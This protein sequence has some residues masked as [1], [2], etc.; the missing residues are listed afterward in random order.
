MALQNI[1]TAVLL[2]F[3]AGTVAASKR[4]PFAFYRFKKCLDNKVPLHVP[5][6]STY[7]TL[8][9]HNYRNGHVSPTAILL[10]RDE[11]EVQLGVRCAHRTGHKLCV[12]SGGH[13]FVGNSLCAGILLDVG[14]FRS[15]RFVN[16][17]HHLDI[18][19]G[20]TL[21]EVVWKSWN[22]RR[23]W[24]AAGV[25]PGVGISGYMLG[26][27]HGPYEGRLG[28]ACDALVSL[29]VV[30]RF[31]VLRVASRWRYKELFWA[32]CGAGGGQFGVVTSFR[33]KTFSSWMYDR[34]VV[35]RFNWNHRVIGELME[36]WQ[37]YDEMD[38][39]MWVRMEMYRA[40]AEPGMFG[41]GACYDVDSEQECWKR[42]QKAAFFNVPTRKLEF[43]AKVDNALQLQAFFGP[44]GN[45]ARKLA[46]NTRTALLD[47][48]YVDAGAANSRSHKSTFL[49]KRMQKKPPSRKFW[50]SYAELCAY[51]GRASVSWVVCEINLFNNAI[52]KPRDNAFP[53]RGGDMITQ[54]IIGDGTKA[55][56]KYVYN[57]MKT[58]LQPYTSGVYVNYPEP[59]LGRNEYP[60]MYWGKSLPRLEKLKRLYDPDLF[61]SHQQPIPRW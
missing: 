17:K 57:R 7:D 44:D 48:R 52:D 33:T 60:K 51:P 8:A 13:S 31:G 18:G 56:K 24:I 36:K 15:V 43:M 14:N 9:A 49:T 6:T 16:D 5:N 61:F 2:L 55:D 46:P 11:S 53:H 10:P 37:N 22:Y 29:R 12:R 1:V 50:Q 26:G 45:W 58:L 42:L 40:N 21:G 19:A 4:D 41:Y 32:S 35:F 3:F 38:G 20:A 30:D 25:C 28:L 23:R 27:G 34:A 39:K 54:F 59:E 47:K